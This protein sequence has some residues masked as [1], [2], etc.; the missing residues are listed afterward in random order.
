M[1]ARKG[2]AVLGAALSVIVAFELR[3]RFMRF[4]VEGASMEPAF[5]EGDFVIADR[6]SYGGALPSAGDVVL[7]RDPRNAE[8]TL[9]KRVDEANPVFGLWLLGDN[10]G[11][12]TDSRHFGWVPL[13]NLEGRVVARYW[14]L[15]AA[16]MFPAARSSSSRS[17]P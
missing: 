2:G 10:A 12:S 9:L 11:A 8:R 7:A 5:H 14:P 13:D 4:A 1:N 6:W 3:R 17:A 16:A 15:S